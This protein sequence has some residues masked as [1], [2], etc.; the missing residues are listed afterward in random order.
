MNKESGK[1]LIDVSHRTV[2]LWDYSILLGGLYPVSYSLETPLKWNRR[3]TKR[4]GKKKGIDYV[5]DFIFLD[6]DSINCHIYCS[7]YTILFITQS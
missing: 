6:D 3:K 2:T 5:E 1:Y 4:T 7:S